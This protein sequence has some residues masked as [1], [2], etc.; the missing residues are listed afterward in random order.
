MPTKEEIKSAT[1]TKIAIALSNQALKVMI[2]K[3]FLVVF[4]A[5]FILLIVTICVSP[6]QISAIVGAFETIFAPTIYLMSKH[7]FGAKSNLDDP[8]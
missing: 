2:A 5:G 7:Y 4:C 8:W 1:S 6:W 3:V